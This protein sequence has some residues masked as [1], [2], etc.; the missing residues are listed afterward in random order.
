VTGKLSRADLAKVFARLLFIQA[1][2]HRRGM[3]NVGVLLALDGAA[4]RVTGDPA[5]LLARHTEHFNTNPNAAPIVVGGVLRIE[6]ERNA[7]AP[8]SV[9]RFKQA[10]ASA[11][12]AAGDVLFS[13]GLKPLALTLAC[14][15]AIYN[16]FAGLVA[17]AV[18][19]N[20]AVLVLR[21]RGLEFGYARGWG[22]IETVTGSRL[23]RYLGIA[24]SSAALAG[25]ILAGVVVLRAT[26]EGTLAGVTT[27]A[28]AVITWFSAR[29]GIPPS[30]VA[31]ALYPLAWLVAMAL[32]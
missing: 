9:S 16:S 32:T 24:R 1:A 21:Y 20:A 6:E 13:G 3:Q 2:I 22:V 19:Y 14:V 23:Q 27:L 18:L 17:V 25:G 31:I 28:A 10:C 4:S 12:A 29:A 7:G 8:A 30:R 11:L 5:G 26:N 15:S